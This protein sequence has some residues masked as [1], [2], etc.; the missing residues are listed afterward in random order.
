M[1]CSCPNFFSIHCHVAAA[2]LIAALELI[3]AQA[4]H[5]VGRVPVIHLRR[6]PLG[7]SNDSIPVVLSP[8]KGPPCLRFSAQQGGWRRG[9][10]RHRCGSHPFPP[11]SRDDPA[12]LLLRSPRRRAWWQRTRVRGVPRRGEGRGDGAAAAGLLAC[13]PRW[14]HRPLARRASDVPGVPVDR[15]LIHRTSSVS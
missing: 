7:R 14:M 5:F 12:S 3:A 11:C 8:E 13:V 10:H 15:S 2:E 9:A 1:V 6:H 4:G